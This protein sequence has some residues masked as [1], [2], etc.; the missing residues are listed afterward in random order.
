MKT[1]EDYS[2][3]Q[4]IKQIL[5]E[6]NIDPC[7]VDLESLLEA[8]FMDKVKNLGRGAAMA[9]AMAAGI[10]GMQPTQ[11]TQPTQP[12]QQV[13]QQMQ[14]VKDMFDNYSQANPT[15]SP[16]QWSQLAAQYPQVGN[17]VGFVPNPKKPGQWIPAGGADS[18]RVQGVTQVNNDQLSRDDIGLTPYKDGSPMGA[19]QWSHYGQAK[20]PWGG[21]Q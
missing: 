7:T 2:Q 14:Q 18:M 16:Q 19:T 12:P 21:Q 8:G 15:M 13:Q 1:F 17:S 20:S 9:G 6:E 4:E 11:P 3:L 10:G 5:I